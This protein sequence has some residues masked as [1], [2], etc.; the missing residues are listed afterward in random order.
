MA[1]TMQH[2]KTSKPA[3]HEVSSDDELADQ[4]LDFPLPP[5]KASSSMPNVKKPS[6]KRP[7]PA[8][9]ASIAAKRKQAP[10]KAG[11][12][13]PEP[14]DIK[15]PVPEEDASIQDVKPRPAKKAR[16]GHAPAAETNVRGVSGAAKGKAKA[17][18]SFPSPKS[19]GSDVKSDDQGEVEAVSQAEDSAAEVDASPHLSG[20]ATASGERLAAP[21]ASTSRK[22]TVAQSK[23]TE[24]R[25]KKRIEELTSQRDSAHQ[26]FEDLAK[27]R[28]T[29]AEA[30]YKQY[31]IAAEQRA[32]HQ[33]EL[34][35]TLTK[36]IAR[37]EELTSTGRTTSLHLLT[38]EG[39]DVKLA[40]AER[41]A[42]ELKEEVARL[43]AKNKELEEQNQ[44]LQSDLTA[45]IKRGTLLADQLRSARSNAPAPRHAPINSHSSPPIRGSSRL[46]ETPPARNQATTK[47]G[48]IICFYEDLTNFIIPNF[49]VS[50]NQ[51]GQV[52]NFNCVLTVGTRCLNFSLKS[53]FHP[54]PT[55]PGP[56]NPH[57]GTLLVHQMMYEPLELEKERDQE[58]LENLDFLRE[59]FTFERKQL[60][61]FLVTLTQKLKGDDGGAESP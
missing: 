12:E 19:K 16:N 51:H 42:Q 46:P 40:D 61:V 26:R 57:A 39:A 17:A 25:Y 30:E 24:A 44:T 5:P 34:I 59:P 9:S 29:E 47:N 10:S 45:E 21:V 11:K 28:E 22:P 2:D 6:S 38:R 20:H 48:L 58:F 8:T 18:S 23:K 54:T 27:L 43:T 35:E 33:D 7:A 50:H 56:S 55:T 15:P 37:I 41:R 32:R 13:G 60:S 36:Q 53:F 3:V 1:R 52:L 49:S 4:Y 14:E 31:R